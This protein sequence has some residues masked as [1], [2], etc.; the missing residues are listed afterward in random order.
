M[1][2]AVELLGRMP[3]SE[4]TFILH[5]LRPALYKETEYILTGEMIGEWICEI[6]LGVA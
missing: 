1:A 3:G 6:S 4:D 2:G 5:V